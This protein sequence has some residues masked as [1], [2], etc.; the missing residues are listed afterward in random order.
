[1]FVSRDVIDL[2]P[3]SFEQADTLLATETALGNGRSEEIRDVVYVKPA[4]FE[5]KHTLQ[6]AAEIDAMNADLVA[7]NR[8][9]L[10]IGF[11]RWG[12]SDPWLGIPVQWSQIAGARALVEAT[13]P[14]MNVE[15]SQGSHFFHN[16]A[17][18]Q[19]SYF[20]IRHGRAQGI[21]WDWLDAQ[22]A[23]AEGR[24]VRRLRLSRPLL[25]EV[26]GRCGR[27]RIGG[28]DGARAKS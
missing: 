13:L 16:L 9:Y 11:G 6:I 7:E 24:F 27:G 10:L 21:A 5:A 17:S 26:D 4:T 20:M 25:V 18:F 8:P 1:M 2:S 22:P 3:T 19:V 28:A 12:S 14:E 23:A 15:A